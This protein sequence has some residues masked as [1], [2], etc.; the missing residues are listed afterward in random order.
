MN[1]YNPSRFSPLPPEPVA[2]NYGHDA[3]HEIPLLLLL[4]PVLRIVY[5]PI[6]ISTHV[7]LQLYSEIQR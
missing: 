7:S 4:D 5:L 3:N 6:S 2:L 1:L